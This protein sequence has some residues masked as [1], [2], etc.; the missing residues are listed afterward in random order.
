MKHLRRRI[1]ILLRTNLGG[2][3]ETSRHAVNFLLSVF[4]SIYC[5]LAVT[6]SSPETYETISFT[7]SQRWFIEFQG[8]SVAEGNTRTALQAQ[9]TQFQTLAAR[10]NLRYRTRY[11]YSDIHNMIAIKVEGLE[12]A[13]ALPIVA[14]ALGA[15]LYPV[16]EM[17]LS[18][19]TSTGMI[20]ADIVRQHHGLSGRDVKVA[21]IDSGIDYTHPDL[22]GC[23]G[24]GCKV[25]AGYDFVGD[26]YTGG[27]T[28]EPQP[29]NDPMDNCHGHGTHVAGIIGAK[30]ASKQGVTGIA[31][32]VKFGIYRVVGCRGG[33][34]EDIVIAAMLEAY[35]NGAQVINLSLGAPGWAQ[36]PAARFASLLTEKGIVVVAAQGNAGLDGQYRTSSPAVGGGVIAVTAAVNTHAVGLTI[37]VS[38]DDTPLWYQPA[39]AAPVSFSGKETLGAIASDSCR[40]GYLPD[41]YAQVKDKVV[42]IKYLGS[43]PAYTAA[44][45]AQAAGARG[46]LFHPETLHI[47][48][49]PTGIFGG[50]S[51]QPPIVSDPLLSIPVGHI[52]AEEALPLRERIEKETVMLTWTTEE[53]TYSLRRGGRIANFGSW[54]PTSELEIK[55]DV[56]APGFLILSTYPTNQ[57]SYAT[58]SGTSM[59]APHVAGA[60]ALLLE[61]YPKV[62][63]QEIAI[64]L[65]N[66]AKPQLRQDPLKVDPVHHQ[67]AGLIDVL[68]ALESTTTV[69]PA[70]LAL[71][72]FDPGPHSAS[73]TITNHNSAPTEYHLSFAPAAATSAN[74]YGPQLIDAAAS[75]EIKPSTVLVAPGQSVT[76]EV[77]V[78]APAHPDIRLFGGHLQI[79]TATGGS[80]ER[81]VVPLLGY[82]GDYQEIEHLSS[83][84]LGRYDQ[85]GRGIRRLNPRITPT[86][87]FERL[88]YAFA[89][90]QI[91]HPSP[92]VQVFVQDES[93]NEWLTHDL[94]YVIRGR[95]ENSYLVAP[96]DGSIV[97]A[98]GEII[99]VPNGRYRFVVIVDKALGNGKENETQLSNFFTIYRDPPLEPVH[100]VPYSSFGNYSIQVDGIIDRDPYGE[101]SDANRVEVQTTQGPLTLYLKHLELT[102]AQGRNDCEIYR[103]NPDFRIPCGR[104]LALGIASDESENGRFIDAELYFD[105]GPRPPHGGGSADGV[106]TPGQEDLKRFVFLS[107]TNPDPGMGLKIDP[108]IVPSCGYYF[109]QVQG[110]P[111]PSGA[112]WNPDY[113]A[114]YCRLNRPT[115]TFGDQCF[116]AADETRRVPAIGTSLR[117]ASDGYFVS[118]PNIWSSSATQIR[119]LAFFNEA[120]GQA[121][122]LIPFQTQEG[123][124]GNLSDVTFDVG[125]EIGLFLRIA[126]EHATEVGIYPMLERTWAKLRILP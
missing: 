27:A 11:D 119:F 43:C 51:V 22:G 98:K 14:R 25:E 79:D 16:S 80:L 58:F 123:A 120:R 46:V 18:L 76:V 12:A 103:L 31:P 116:W 102:D 21:V 49:Q 44:R 74:T 63:P 66:S 88:D 113:E 36:S 81:A 100:N 47:D 75:V 121:E 93:G 95:G 19:A 24:P 5:G 53:R 122:F 30:A 26:A 52:A 6:A 84:S 35:K 59:A 105:E 101:W 57:G 17:Q 71:G 10:N 117:A 91:A 62:S 109:G 78:H 28:S 112:P 99:N 115:D 45:N 55:P 87:T 67:G 96:W 83:V 86:Y 94:Y 85:F 82:Q 3:Y 9:R 68:R 65:S 69:T 7:T 54:G 32:E 33:T 73:L 37:R 39:T 92:R 70:N 110:C 90:M 56:S 40:G 104:Y 107:R 118:P 4:I 125:D 34:S 89:V 1:T 97:D 42:L 13:A 126:Y 77:T 15:K 106:L 8:G 124:P 111:E 20:G 72:E 2:L 23:F 108:G 50:L 41:E 38:P 114:W 48:N 61:A 64:W 60:A 29:D